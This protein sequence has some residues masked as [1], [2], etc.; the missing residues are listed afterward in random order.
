MP[1]SIKVANLTNAD[2]RGARFHNTSFL[3]GSSLRR[4]T[5]RNTTCQMAVFE[6]V[7]FVS[8]SAR[9]LAFKIENALIG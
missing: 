2:L 9:R 5:F 8:I 7:E 1:V 4:T 3:E 6:I